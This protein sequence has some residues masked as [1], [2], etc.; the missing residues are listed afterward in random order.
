M[1]MHEPPISAG[2]AAVSKAR[3]A[4]RALIGPELLPALRFLPPQWYW[5]WA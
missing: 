4:R 5:W 3:A 1:R 2:H